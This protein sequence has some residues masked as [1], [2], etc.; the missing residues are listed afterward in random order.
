MT[1]LCHNIGEKLTSNYN[2]SK[3]IKKA[4]GQLTFDGVYENVW[5]HRKIICKKD[6]IIFVM[7]NYVGGDNSFDVGQPFERFCTWKQ[8]ESLVNNGT[9]L[10]WHTWSHP[11]LT[12]LSYRDILKELTPPFP[13]DYVAYPYG[14]F[15]DLCLKAVEELGYKEAF[16]VR[17]GDDSRFQRL[18][19]Y[20]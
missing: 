8:I 17:R 4:E 19:R 2:T 11:N 18:R 9:K 6:V 1:Y 13:M 7:G 20:L 15:N 14:K 16:S 5:R 10:G 3:E 12:R